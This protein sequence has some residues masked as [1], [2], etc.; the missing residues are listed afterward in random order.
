MTKLKNN[1]GVTLVALSVTILIMVIITSA[2][3]YNS[4][5][6]MTSRQL[7]NL[8]N[9]VELLKDRVSTYYIKNGELPILQLKLENINNLQGINVNDNENYYVIDLSLLS[10]ITLNYGK[11]YQN[12]KNGETSSDVYVINEQSHNIYYPKGISYDNIIYYTKAEDY[13]EIKI[14]SYDRPYIPKDFTYKEGTWETGFVIKQNGTENEFVWIPVKNYEEFVADADYKFIGYSDTTNGY[15]ISE[16]HYKNMLQSV[17]NNGGFYISRYE[18]GINQAR[19]NTTSASI[20]VISKQNIYP[21]NFVTRTQAQTLA[22]DLIVQNRTTSLMYGIQ[23]DAIL[24]FISEYENN[25]KI[26]IADGGSTNWGNYSNSAFNIDVLAKTKYTTNGTAWQQTT[27]NKA[28]INTWAL[29]T[30][31]STQNKVLNIYDLAGNMSEYTLEQSSDAS[32]RN[33]TRGGNCSNAGT[34][35]TVETRANVSENTSEFNIGFRI[36]IW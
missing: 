11:G 13:S 17:K 12:I 26:T 33:V 3:V 27:A 5:K 23:W 2:L 35:I 28:S 24:R 29:T 25:Y 16:Q 22:Q 10:N 9:D 7:T 18:A 20:Q 36:A 15:A 4:S 34:S 1:K 8:Y 32:A 14:N 31:A 30:G 6:G 21:Y 19:V